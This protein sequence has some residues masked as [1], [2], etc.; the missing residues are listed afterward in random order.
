MGTP[1]KG[2]TRAITDLFLAELAGAGD[3]LD[4]IILPND[5]SELCL[6]CAGCILKGE[7][8]CPHR[9]KLA[10]L[11]EKLEKADLIILASPV[12]VMSCTAA[13]KAFF[14]HLGFMWLIHR[15]REVMFGKVGLI[16]TT[17]GGSGIKETVKLLRQNLFYLGVPQIFDY[18]MTTM[19]MGGNYAEYAHKDKI[20]KQV[21]AKAARVRKALASPKVGSK[22]KFFFGLFGMTQKKGWNKT[23]SDYWRE[24][25]WLD[26]KKPF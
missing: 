8:K 5:F 22:T 11:I 15:P 18:S 4:E 14:D 9:E 17:A 20:K 21:A 13:M 1:H 26:G 23:D 24:K 16:I 7:D 19:K 12:F 25:G 6:G 10:P 3:T 2:N